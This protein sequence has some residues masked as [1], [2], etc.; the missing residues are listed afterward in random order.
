MK[1]PNIQILHRPST[2]SRFKCKPLYLHHRHSYSSGGWRA[3]FAHRW[4]SY[5][6]DVSPLKKLV[7]GGQFYSFISPLS[8]A[9]ILFA[10]VALGIA[11][12]FV[13]DD[14]DE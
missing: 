3:F 10:S 13:K 1:N 6:P 7:S 14:N 9:V 2:T 12:V 4:P 8:W 5:K 11:S